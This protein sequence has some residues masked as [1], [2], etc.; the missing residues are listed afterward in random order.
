MEEYFR[1]L[2]PIDKD[3]FEIGRDIGKIYTDF[4][5]PIDMAIEHLVESNHIVNDKRSKVQV[6][7][8][9]QNWLI[10]HRMNSNATEKAINRQRKS[11]MQTMLAFIKTGES[12]IY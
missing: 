7:S 5:L 10:E 2:I 8:G 12:G 1:L 9:A 6:L 11:N 4:G 3:L